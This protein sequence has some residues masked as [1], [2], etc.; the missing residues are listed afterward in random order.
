M[1]S[2][3]EQIDEREHLSGPRHFESPPLGSRMPFPV[4]RQD[5]RLQ[6]VGIAEKIMTWGEGEALSAGRPSIGYYHRSGDGWVNRTPNL[7]VWAKASQHQ[8]NWD[9][10]ARVELWC[11][12]CMGTR[13][14]KAWV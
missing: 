7:S 14:S 13:E 3:Q 11:G 9:L 5:V 4:N 12:Y 1:F 2:T 8:N 6:L 10:I